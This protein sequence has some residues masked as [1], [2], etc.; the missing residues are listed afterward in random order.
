MP[1]R[2]LVLFAIVT[3]SLPAFAETT[4]L[5]PANY[6][7]LAPKGKEVDAIHGDHVLR[8]DWLVA[9]V[10]APGEERDANL[11]VRNVGGS[12][13]DLTAR[14]K[15]NDQLSCFYPGGG[16]YRFER[17]TEWDAEAWGEAEG[18]T[19]AFA[20]KAQSPAGSPLAIAVGYELRDTE[21]FVRVVSTVTNTGDEPIDM[22]PADGVRADGDT[23]KRGVDH[24]ANLWWTYDKYWRQAYGLQPEGGSAQIDRAKSRGN[25]SPHQII[26]PADRETEEPVTLAPGAAYTWKRRLF[27]AASNVAL[28]SLAYRFLGV[29]LCEGV[30]RV[31]DGAE[32]IEGAE[33]RVIHTIQHEHQGELKD[34]RVSLGVGV[35]DAAGE[36]SINLPANTYSLRVRAESHGSTTDEIVLSADGGA[37]AVVELPPCGY[38]EGTIT[39]AAGKAIPAKVQFLGVGETR[40][41]NWGPES[42]V[43]QVKNVQY[44]PDG[45]F[46][47]KLLPGEYRWIASYG[48]EHDAAFGVIQ[49][50]AGETAPIE[51]ALRRSVATPGWLSSELHSHSSPSGDNTGSQRGRVLNLLAEHLE[52]CPCTEHQR[53]DVY[54]EHLLAFDAQHRMLTCPGMELTGSPLP[55]NHQNAFPLVHKRHEQDGGGPQTHANPVK[56][57]ERIAFWDDNSEKV[58]QTN[59]P[60][61][62]QMIGDRDQ[63]GVADQGFEGMFAH[64]DAFEVHPPELIFEPL[65]PAEPTESGVGTGGWEGR[66][67]A[68]VN[69]LQMLNLGYRLTAVVNTD[70][71]YNWHGSGWLRNWVKSSTDIPAEASVAELIHEFEHGHV[72]VS[73]GPYLQVSAQ[74]KIE[75]SFAATPTV[76]PGDD[77]SAPEG[78]ATFR[79]TV[80]CPNWIKINRV[81]LF[82]NGRP[83]EEH[84]YTAR[85]H[86]DLFAEGP[87]VFDQTIE[88]AVDEDTHVV[89]ACCGEGQ[90]IGTMYGGSELKQDWGRRMPVAVANPIFLDTDGDADDD[91]APFEANGDDLG[92]PLPTPEGFKPSHGHTHPNHRHP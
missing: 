2:P 73:N 63:D 85:S 75:D 54:D 88:L 10:A 4:T 43:R 67:N 11:T 61:I 82:L 16:S 71:H 79:V 1:A 72:V 53:I 3:A 42:A 66:G 51:A 59:H 90:S 14:D 23:F 22:L 92:L 37:T 69:W 81:Q 89:V 21:A 7:A 31:T 87:E 86:R 35:T 56:Q 27:P 58:V 70:A 24:E 32:P 29:P 50:A 47:C 36:F 48:P 13:I 68:I 76:L 15:P 64:M 57:I 45:R 19:L 34:E 65:N 33:V 62:A 80:R 30:V 39:E 78:K 12:I 28:Q 60:D 6:D 55:L 91:G 52:F 74:A 84:N 25:R 18:E 44:T 83:V 20:G 17:K 49:V 77:L 38:A 9:V 40:S 46:R 26:Y 5:T 41:P 8:N